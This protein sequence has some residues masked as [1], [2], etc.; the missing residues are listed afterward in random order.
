MIRCDY[1]SRSFTVTPLGRLRKTYHEI[2]HG[3]DIV[4]R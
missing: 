2:L 3:S 1:C 4:N